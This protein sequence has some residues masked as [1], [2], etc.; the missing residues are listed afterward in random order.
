[1][2]DHRENLHHLSDGCARP[3]IGGSRR[4][5]ISG[6]GRPRLPKIALR[7]H[8]VFARSSNRC[9]AAST[10]ARCSWTH[11]PNAKTGSLAIEA[12][13][14]SVTAPGIPMGGGLVGNIVRVTMRSR[15]D[16]ASYGSASAAM[17]LVLRL[18]SLKRRGPSAQQ[19][20][21]EHAP[22]LADAR[23]DRWLTVPAVLAQRV[24]HISIR[25]ILGVPRSHKSAFVENMEGVMLICRH[26]SQ[27]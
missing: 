13:P 14:S 27:V 22:L 12:G 9:L 11:C 26:G 4:G 2:S 10:S 15:R 17:P 24:V 21:D 7:A 3:R 6:V 23:E 8:H 25:S 5:R 20:D 1:M 18:M 19:H 16:R